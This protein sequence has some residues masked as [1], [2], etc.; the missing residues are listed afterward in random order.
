MNFLSNSITALIMVATTTA[1][2]I[3][4]ILG[5]TR[6][7][8]LISAQVAAANTSVGQCKSG[9]WDITPHR[10]L[11]YDWDRGNGTPI[12][13]LSCDSPMINAAALVNPTITGLDKRLTIAPSRN[14]PSPNR[15]T[16]TKKASIMESSMKW[17]VPG[18][19]SGRMAAADM[20]DSMA[21]GPVWSWLHDPHN[22]ATI[23][24]MNEAYSPYTTGREASCAYAMLWGTRISATVTP[25]TRSA[26]TFSAR[27]GNQRKKGKRL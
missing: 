24:G 26:R 8:P 5:L 12:I 10:S 3:P 21:T 15:S 1:I 23:T 22:A 25:A 14:N 18:V 16:P 20:S 7:S 2:R 4:G 17:S 19:A 27:N 13:L 9:I 6:R 11:R